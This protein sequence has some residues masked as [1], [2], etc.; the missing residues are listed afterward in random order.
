MQA[1]ELEEERTAET[2][3][4]P[5]PWWLFLITGIGWLV[6]ALVVLRFD[7]TSIA[8]VGVLLGV[9][10]AFAG[11]TEVVA[12]T[13]GAGW[14]WAHWLLAALF[15]IGSIWSFVHPVGAF[16][17][18][19][20]ILGLLLVLKGSFDIVSSIATRPVNDLWWLG[21]VAGIVEVLLAFWVSQQF[22]AP[23]AALIIVWVGFSAI[24]RGIGEIAMA[25]D[26]RGLERDVTEA[27][28]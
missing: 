13:T 14:R 22:F 12:A 6:A 11:G 4:S 21:L 20:S 3:R 18:L 23:R 16:W 26:V 15:A 25:F 19:A 8:A 9:V 27:R 7:A 5:V 10:L 28:S 2:E 17:E 24:L 1:R